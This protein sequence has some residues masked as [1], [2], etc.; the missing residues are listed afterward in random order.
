VGSSDKKSYIQGDLNVQGFT[1]VI[2]KYSNRRFFLKATALLGFAE[3]TGVKRINAMTHLFPFQSEACSGGKGIVTPL[4]HQHANGGEGVPAEMSYI[5]DLHCHPTLKVYL[6]GDHMWKHHLSWRGEN[7]L[8]MQVDI[9]HLK[10]GNVRGI[11]AAHHLPE[12]GLRD[13]AYTLRKLLPFIRTFA[14][15]FVSKLENGNASNFRQLTTMMDDFEDH[16]QKTNEHSGGTAIAIAKS[17]TEF[18]AIKDKGMIAVAQAVEG[19]HALGRHMALGQY[20]DNLNFLADRGIALITLSHFFANDLSFPVEGMA[21]TDKTHFHL[22]W[23]YDPT[24]DNRGLTDIGKLVVRQMLVRGI[25]VDM[26]HMTPKGREDVFRINDDFFQET[27]IRRPV[28]FTHTGAQAVVDK[29]TTDPS[30]AEYRNY[31]YIAVRK[32]EV[33]KI[34]ACN[35]VIG[36]VFMNFWLIGNDTHT[37]SE[38]DAGAKYK[39]G[40]DNIL[41]TIAYL[42]EIAGDYQ[43]IA[44]GS[45]FDGFA[46]SLKD[47]KNPKYYEHLIDAM[48]AAKIS[49]EDIARITHG[50]AERVLKMGWGKPLVP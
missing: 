45:D 15:V 6:L 28:I 50:N 30:M 14:P 39:K 34:C 19:S 44:I 25:V 27:K 22:N 9:H 33:D 40:I 29:H 37:H 17:Y 32:E 13:Q 5:V 2:M 8:H 41:E 11:L 4:P 47:L 21:P 48:K 31:K 38:Q 35:G 16:V 42:K 43:N 23:K 10:K 12:M 3:F 36:I 24:Y 20:L 18:K 46:D 49:D 1:I 7:A 26:T